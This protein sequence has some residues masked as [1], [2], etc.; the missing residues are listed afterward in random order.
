[1]YPHILVC[2]KTPA[3]AGDCVEIL[4]PYSQSDLKRGI[5]EASIR[6]RSQSFVKEFQMY[7]GV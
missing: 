6:Q 7:C 2:Q 4:R 1:M 3:V 5:A